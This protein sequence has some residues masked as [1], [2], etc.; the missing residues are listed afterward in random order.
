MAS[1]LMA[2]AVLEAGLGSFDE[3]RGSLSRAHN[4]LD[5]V[6]LTVWLAGPYAQA[7]GWVELLAGEPGAAE[8][9]LR[10]GF[11]TL[12]EIGEMTW[13]S[14]VAGLLAEAVLQAGRR[15]EA[16]VLAEA[17]HGA[18]APDDVYS[19]VVWRAVAS[20]VH[21]YRGRAESA[22][23]LAQEAVDL[24][25]RTDCP[26][27]HWYAFMNLAR[28]LELIGHFPDAASAADKAAEAARLKGGVVAERRA[29]ETAT[30]LGA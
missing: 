22:E 5:E 29:R 23:A 6:A 16:E 25:R 30:R 1:S 17:S 7:A 4:L 9:A 28:V 24:I 26:L 12:R 19:Q 11:D 13:F 20:T 18:A 8:R 27:L 14:T 15:D 2:Q 3:A 21:A 10:A